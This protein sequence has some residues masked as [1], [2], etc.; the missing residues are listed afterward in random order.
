MGSSRQIVYVPT[1]AYRGACSLPITVLLLT[2]SVPIRYE[3]VW[4]TLR[5]AR[6]RARCVRAARCIPAVPVAYVPTVAYRPC[7]LRT[8]RPLHTGRARW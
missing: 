7:S 3:V 8:Y 6:A 2:Q 4:S 5:T 1:V